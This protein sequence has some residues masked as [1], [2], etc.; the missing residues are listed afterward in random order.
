[1]TKG[2]LLSQ[3]CRIGDCW[4]WEGMIFSAG[5]GAIMNGGSV[6]YAHRAAYEL[7]IGP[8]PPK[9]FVCHTC[10]VRNCVNPE[11][12]FLGTNADNMADKTRKGRTPRGDNHWKRK[13]YKN[14]LAQSKII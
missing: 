2:D 6:M 1:M 4:L 9:L 5:Y 13:W 11:H 12:L 7:Y 10:D 14:R 3:I 8:I